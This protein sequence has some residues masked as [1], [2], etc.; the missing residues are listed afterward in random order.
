MPSAQNLQT[1]LRLKAAPGA[2]WNGMMTIGNLRSGRCVQRPEVRTEVRL[3][4]FVQRQDDR[5]LSSTSHGAWA[6]RDKSNDHLLPLQAN[7]IC[8]LL[9]FLAVALITQHPAWFG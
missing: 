2:R 5:R 1:P 6:M 9:F 4:I 7:I 3:G 8:L